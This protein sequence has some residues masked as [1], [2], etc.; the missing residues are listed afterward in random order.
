MGSGIGSLPR[1][2]AISGLADID[3]ADRAPVRPK[4]I[5]KSVATK[6]VDTPVRPE[7]LDP[8]PA[9]EA[10][11][12]TRPEVRFVLVGV[13]RLGKIEKA[14][15]IDQRDGRRHIMEE[16]DRVDGYEILQIDVPG[17]TVKLESPDHKVVTLVKRR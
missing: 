9:V 17:L 2:S 15:I 6:H 10:P 16:K 12:L 13:A 5:K 8:I 11:D 14:T 1:G 7:V 4:P 3:D